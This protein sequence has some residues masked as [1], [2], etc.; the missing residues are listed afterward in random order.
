M[1]FEGEDE[2][3]SLRNGSYPEQLG[4]PKGVEHRDLKERR[5]EA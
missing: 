1:D 2:D 5:L 4:T 3:P